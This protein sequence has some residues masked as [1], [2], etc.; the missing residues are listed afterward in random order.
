LSTDRAYAVPGY[1]LDRLIGKGGFGLVFE[2]RETAPPLRSVAVKILDPS[3]FADREK[4]YARFRRE[5]AALS[6]LEHPNIVRYIGS[7]VTTD[8]PPFPF[9]A[10][11]LVV[12]EQFRSSLDITDAERIRFMIQVLGGLDHAH[13]MGLFH[14]D[15]KPSNLLLRTHDRQAIIVDFGL[16]I[17]IEDLDPNKLTT[18]YAGSTGYVPPEVLAGTEPSRANHDIF[19]CG[20]TLYEALVGTRPNIQSYAPLS[21]QKARLSAL[22]PVI[23]KSLDAVATRYQSAASFAADLAGVL[24]HVEAIQGLAD[25]NPRAEAFRLKAVERM[26]REK[27]AREARARAQAETQAHWATFN[28]VVVAGAERAFND[29]VSVVNELHGPATFARPPEVTAAQGR[30]TKL[31]ELRHKHG[32][33]CFGLVAPTTSAESSVPWPDSQRGA[34]FGHTPRRQLPTVGPNI[35]RLA[36]EWVVYTDLGAYPPIAIQGAISAIKVH[37]MDFRLFAKPLT[38]WHGTMGHT[39]R[40]PRLLATVEDVRSYITDTIGS[41]FRLD[42]E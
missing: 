1:E 34:L 36:P 4:S 15:I 5:A 11:D 7:G 20:V 17:D 24:A 32:T 13:R 30:P 12:G 42:H 2:A 21:S 31:F 10:T 41:H 39:P 26:A 3:A 27:A 18:R 19:S 9:L 14:R 33:L 25:T 16:V 28:D 6:R 8:E 38:E 23:R 35:E 40:E 22:D 29:M 37:L